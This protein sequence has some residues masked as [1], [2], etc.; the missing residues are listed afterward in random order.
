MLPLFACTNVPA[1]V[2]APLN[3]IGEFGVTFTVA[4]API[5][6]G[7]FTAQAELSLVSAAVAPGATVTGTVSG[8]VVP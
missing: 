7:P 4:P 2:T 5:V 3:V 6:S 8:S 1:F